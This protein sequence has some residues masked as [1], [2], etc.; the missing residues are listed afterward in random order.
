MNNP[1]IMDTFVEVKLH[2]EDDFVIIME[3]LTRIGIASRDSKRLTQTCHILHKKGKYYIQ[4]FL[5]LFM[6]DGKQTHFTA[7]DCARRN[8]IISLLEQWNLLTVV[9]PDAIKEP[10]ASLRRIMIIKAEDKKSES[11]PDGWE[12]CSKYTVGKR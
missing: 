12:L 4:H 8:T 9:N 1:S 11:N 6:L 10:R 5:E 7:E 2:H 3:T